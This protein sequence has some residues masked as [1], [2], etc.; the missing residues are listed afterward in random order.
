MSGEKKRVL[1]IIS[2]LVTGGAEMMLYKL[3]ANSN[4]NASSAILCLGGKQN[5]IIEKDLEQLG[6]K[7]YYLGIKS[8]VMSFKAFP[9][10]KNIIDN[11]KP[12]TI[13]GWMYHGNI[14]A[15]MS[16]L[17]TSKV[18]VIW[19][20]RHSLHDLKN[21]KWMMQ[22]TI[23]LN[24]WL[25]SM[26]DVIIFN[27]KSSVVQH[28]DYGFSK[29]K[30]LVIPNG[31]DLQD[32]TPNQEVKAKV[33]KELGIREG[34]LVIGCVARFHPTKG[35]ALFL[36]AASLLIEKYSHV[37][38]VL[39]GKGMD[40]DNLDMVNMISELGL[41]EKVILLGER[42]DVVSLTMAF[43]IAT[44]ASLSEAFSNTIGEAMAAQVPCVVTDVGDSAWIVGDFGRVVPPENPE[45]LSN[46]WQ[47][48]LALTD[49]ERLTL[50]KQARR[51][52]EAHFSIQHIVKKYNELY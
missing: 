38:F 43:D 29:A 35:H 45:A 46:A 9:Q 31:F 13:Q 41:S 22:C 49:L 47:K 27:S 24:V 42:S 18:K 1:H 48:L 17:L 6:I 19:S 3:L 25:S 15:L 32:F 5:T 7:I 14:V 12:T 37:V 40:C 33:R 52:I 20:V 39:V 23:K 44:S 8:K 4:S 50:G 36:K 16:Q 34:D 11:F 28:E 26:P 21:D 2:G 51:R 30:T 10:L